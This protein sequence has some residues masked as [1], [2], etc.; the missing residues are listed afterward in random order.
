MASPLS[1]ASGSARIEGWRY[2]RKP[3]FVCIRRIPF[4]CTQYPI[5]IA[6]RRIDWQL[7]Q[8]GMRW[9]P[10]TRRLT[11]RLSTALA[12]ALINGNSR[13]SDVSSL[14]LAKRLQNG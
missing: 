4:G 13:L 9:L 1:S 10:G 2:E 11:A 8:R 5:A 12:F 7:G 14:T 6:L 3:L